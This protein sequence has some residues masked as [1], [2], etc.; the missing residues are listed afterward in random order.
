M[1]EGTGTEVIM[2]ESMAVLIIGEV[3]MGVV[4]T[5]EVVV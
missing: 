4:L 1:V 2:E 5:V 3:S